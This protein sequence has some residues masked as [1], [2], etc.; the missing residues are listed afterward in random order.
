VCGG[1]ESKTKKRS[2]SETIS[3]APAPA[4][5]PSLAFPLKPLVE[6]DPAGYF[7]CPIVNIRDMSS[8][9]L[10]MVKPLAA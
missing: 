7:S 4:Q 9:F 5:L 8:V 6:L 2:T 10:V 1:I 3:A